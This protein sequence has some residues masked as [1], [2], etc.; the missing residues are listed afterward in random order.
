MHC[1][2]KQAQFQNLERPRP[3]GGQK[4]LSQFSGLGS[5]VEPISPVVSSCD[6]RSTSPPEVTE[7]GPRSPLSGEREQFFE[8]PVPRHHRDGKMEKEKKIHPVGRTDESTLKN[9]VDGGIYV[10]M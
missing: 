7:S 4:G 10:R 9:D 2:F 8:D 3:P 5:P 6:E 1:A